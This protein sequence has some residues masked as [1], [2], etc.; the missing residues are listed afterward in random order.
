M[1]LV[2]LVTYRDAESQVE[3]LGCLVEDCVYSLTETCPDMI[4]L[5]RAG[6]EGMQQARKSAAQVDS[7]VL[8]GRVANLELLPPV[9]KP[10]KV[11]ALA[12]NYVEHIRES[13]RAK[14]TRMGETRK[15]TP[16]V[17]MKPPSTGLIGPEAPIVLGKTAHFVDYE[18]EL[19]VVIGREARYVKAKNAA[20][21]IA[22]YT[23]LNDISERQFQVWER[24]DTAEWDK[25]FD[26][27][28]GKWGDGFAPMGPCLVPAA[29]IGDP[30][31]LPLE[32]RLNGETMQSANTGDM[33][34]SVYE[35]VEY[36]SHIC[37][38]EPGDCIATGTPAGVGFARQPPVKLQDGDVVEA[39]I[40]P[41]GVL[42]SPVKA[43]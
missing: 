30:Q 29:D 34:F 9:P 35:I 26:W 21:Y 16:R 5:L 41:I 20:D 1:E 27:L 10:N 7:D 8:V 13:S 14:V 43:E 40:Q 38:L 17:F 18:V 19:A 28:N 4:C 25:W 2:R 6:P 15:T 11:F 31:D 24:E 36:V 3:R 23:I 42:R 33:I 22:G 39:E 37:T 32:L 12:G